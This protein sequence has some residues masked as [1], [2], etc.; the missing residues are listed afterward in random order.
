MRFDIIDSFLTSPTGTYSAVPDVPCSTGPSV[1]PE[2]VGGMPTSTTAQ[3]SAAQAWTGNK[4]TAIVMGLL[5]TV[6]FA[7]GVQ[8][9]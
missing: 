4:L 8:L 3:S 7:A 9:V 6:L 5:V 1:D 2:S